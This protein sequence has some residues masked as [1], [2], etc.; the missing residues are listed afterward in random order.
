MKNLFYL[1][2]ALP[3]LFS[4]GDAG[5]AGEEAKEFPEKYKNKTI[6]EVINPRKLLRINDDNTFVL[7]IYHAISGET[8]DFTGKIG[9]YDPDNSASNGWSNRFNVSYDGKA[10]YFPRVNSMPVELLPYWEV[11]EVEK[12]IR[13]YEKGFNTID[14]KYEISDLMF[15]IKY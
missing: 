6:S 10:S 7:R 2:I 3:L 4:C 9:R 15:R 13:V 11:I 1:L 14:G 12:E 5:D 8:F